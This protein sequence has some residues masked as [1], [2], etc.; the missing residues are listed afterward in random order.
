MNAGR[1]RPSEAPLVVGREVEFPVPPDEQNLYATD[2]ERPE[3][4]FCRDLKGYGWCFRKQHYVNIGFGRADPESLPQAT[5]EFVAFLEER[6][7][8]PHPPLAP[9]RGHAYLLNDAAHRRIVDEGVALVG[10]AAGLAYPQSGEGIRPAIESGLLAAAAIVEAAGRYT[11][12]R[13]VP[14]EMRLRARLGGGGS[15]RGVTRL[16]PSRFW[17]P[18]GTALLARPGFVRRVALDRWF[19]H[20]GE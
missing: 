6:Q 18:L 9:W 4:Y 19:L 14:Y 5:A 12:E 17:M 2:P 20:A 10:D 1:T 8:I 15:A 7:R 13:L 3:L 11:R 16:L